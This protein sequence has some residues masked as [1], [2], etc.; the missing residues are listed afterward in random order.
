[1]SLKRG[2][3]VL[4]C[5][6]LSAFAAS[7]CSGADGAAGKNGAVG[8]TGPVGATGSTGV[9]GPTGSSGPTGATGPTGADGNPGGQGD[10]GPTKPER[11][12]DDKIGGW[13]TANRDALN[14]LL[15]EHGIASDSFDPKQR[16]VAVFDWDNTVTKNDIGDATFAWMLQNDKF[17]QP[18]G[19]DWSK[20]SASLSTAAKTAL[21]T[22]CDA[23]A[24]AGAP[25]PTSSNA[26]CG[27]E[28]MNIYYNG[29]TVAGVAAWDNEITTTNNAPY[30]WVAQLQ[31]GYTP[32][33]IREFAWEAFDE[34]NAAAISTKQTVAGVSMAGYIRVYD[35]IRDLAESL[36]ANGFDV[37]VVSASPQYFVEA[38]AG[39]IGV[40]PDH[41][42]GIRSVVVNGHITADLQGCGPVADGANSLITFYQG[43]RCWINKVIFG[44][45]AASQLA[46]NPNLAKRPTFVAGDSDT[47][48]VMLKDATVL[49][50][51]LERNKLEIMCNALAN[52]N[53]KW[54]HQPMFIEPKA[55]PT[56]PYP[57]STAKEPPPSGATITD[58]AGNPIPDQTP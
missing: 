36:A 9:A 46:Q 6:A 7:A 24:A 25:L 21:N 3:G 37:W 27:A 35:Q 38:V 8:A 29:K 50:L 19:K 57:C 51:A 28:V 20:S 55:K 5:L 10:A 15:L 4:G 48:I 44:E 22:A 56:T 33:E 23:A 16:P 49:K 53:G 32:Q 40:P 47:D 13:E 42:V 30:A 58:E 11:L 43:K 26:A 45:P 18:P 17:L 12:L 1:M 14:E 54:L 34:N 52:T 31:A 41:V 39:Q 2:F